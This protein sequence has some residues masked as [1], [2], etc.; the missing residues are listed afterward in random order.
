MVSMYVRSKLSRETS[1][2]TY[3]SEPREYQIES[4]IQHLHVYP[5]LAENAVRRAVDVV[6]MNC[7]V[8]GG[9][10]RPIQPTA[11]LRDQLGDL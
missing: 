1:K 7:T 11:A 4:L 6:E 9:E 10:E 8:N 5:E 3:Q 2:W